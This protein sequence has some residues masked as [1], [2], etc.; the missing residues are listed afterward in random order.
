M[1]RKTAGAIQ[2]WS[3]HNVMMCAKRQ[4]EILSS[5]WDTLKTDGILVYSTCTF[6]PAENEH[7]IRWLLGKN[8][9]EVVRLDISGFE[10]ITEIDHEGIYGYG[11]HPGKIRGEG[12]F[13]AVIRKKSAG[14]ERFKKSKKGNDQQI[15]R[16]ERETVAE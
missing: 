15:S 4:R 3:E 13:I 1:F 11:F 14:G 8:Q 12:L 6:N 10:G 7:N 5:A 16:E 2:E 9:A